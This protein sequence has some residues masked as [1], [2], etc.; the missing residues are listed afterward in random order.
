MA[1]TDQQMIDAIAAMP[2]GSLCTFGNSGSFWACTMQLAY[3]G[4]P[5][6]GVTVQV[7]NADLTSAFEAALNSASQFQIDHPQ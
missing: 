1:M 4:N 6:L 5:N 7:T 3:P 2:D